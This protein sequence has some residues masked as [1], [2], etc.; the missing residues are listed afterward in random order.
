MRTLRFKRTCRR[1]GR[2]G[3]T[4]IELLTAAVVFMV[5]GLLIAQLLSSA[6]LVTGL[7]NKKQEADAQARL[8]FGRLG[9]DLSK[10]PKRPDVKYYLEKQTGNDRLAFL[11]EVAGYYPSSAKPGSLSVVSYRVGEGT[12]HRGL[13]RLSQGLSW[14]QDA[15]GLSPAVFHREIASLSPDAVG[16]APSDDYEGIG[17]GVLRLEYF[18]L[19]KNG[20]LSETPWD[21]GAGHTE[22]D[23]FR[24]VAAICVVLAV[25]DP[26]VLS[27]VTPA[28]MKALA[29][30]LDDF[31]ASSMTSLGALEQSWQ[32]TVD[33]DGFTKKS[34]GAVRVLS[35]CFPL[36]S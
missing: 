15:T 1:P 29:D 23:G 14:L 19:L 30:K 32:Q 2:A 36:S 4:L 12:D 20:T 17:P 5:L 9:L 21:A 24:D 6:T 34:G 25:V 7:S 33:G 22:V 31:N 28:E 10:M 16:T 35:R 13:E 27:R 11:S 18:F 8:I 26:A 3:F